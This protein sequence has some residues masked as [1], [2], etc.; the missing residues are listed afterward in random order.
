MQNLRHNGVLH[1][2]VVLLTVH[3]L[4]EPF[5]SPEERLRVRELGSGMHRA[6]LCYGFMEKPDVGHDVAGLAE[7]RHPG[8]PRAHV[9]LH[10]PQQRRE[11]RAS[12]AAELAAPIVPDAEPLCRQ[13]HRL[14]SACRPTAPS[15]WAAGSRSS[16]HCAATPVAVRRGCRP[17][18]QPHLEGDRAAAVRSS[19]S[20]HLAAAYVHDFLEDG[21]S[22]EC[23]SVALREVCLGVCSSRSQY[24]RASGMSSDPDG[25]LRLVESP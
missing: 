23:P 2:H 25:M 7:A 24:R 19:K 1:Q 20:G 18:S 8:R 4:D 5:V 3:L 14:L 10:R 17:I 13:P 11:R 21:S 15:S 9:L 22:S 16:L 6:V 12:P